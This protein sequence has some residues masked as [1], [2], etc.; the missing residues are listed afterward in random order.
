[1]S[2]KLGPVYQSRICNLQ[3]SIQRL[4][5]IIPARNEARTIGRILKELQGAGV[6]EIIVV[7]GQSSDDTRE[8]AR[9][10]GANVIESPPGRGRQLNAGAAVAT[11]DTFLF[12]HADTLLPKG[13]LQ[14][15]NNM[16]PNPSCQAG[17]FLHQFS[18]NDWRLRLVSWLDNF[19]CRRSNIIYGDQAFFIRQALF[20]HLGGFPNQPILED[21]ALCEK[22][23][24]HVTPLLLEPPVLTR[25]SG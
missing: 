23:V 10:R 15:L 19:R 18:G 9:Y 4:S 25:T 22:L 16:E 7:D 20:E 14:R 3:S 6:A 8:I 24:G 1:M 13:A 11:G 2:I 21:V 17:G 5:V 12:L